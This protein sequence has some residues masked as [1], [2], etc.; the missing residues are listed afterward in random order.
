MNPW[1]AM[2]WVS[3]E[4]RLLNLGA[5][6]IGR[7]ALVR[8]TFMQ[9]GQSGVAESGVSGAKKSSFVVGGE[10]QVADVHES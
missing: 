9:L 3:H 5:N 4:A 6:S 7:F 10:E 8:G 2:T 1:L